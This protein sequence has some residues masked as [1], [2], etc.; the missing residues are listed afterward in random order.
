MC[1]WNLSSADVSSLNYCNIR[2]AIR[3]HDFPNNVDRNISCIAENI[4]L[5]FFD[6]SAKNREADRVKGRQIRAC[7][8]IS[9]PPTKLTPIVSWKRVLKLTNVGWYAVLSN[10]YKIS[11]NFKLVQFQ[12]KLLMHI[13]TCKYMRH[14]MKIAP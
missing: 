13:S 10:I 2:L 7:T 14:K 6:N 5:R 12:Y 3:A 1:K 9:H 11:R 4:T 8:S